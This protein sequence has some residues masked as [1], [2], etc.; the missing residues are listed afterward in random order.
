M[1]NRR[2]CSFTLCKNFIKETFNKYDNIKNINF[3]IIEVLDNCIKTSISI[4]DKTRV[5]DILLDKKKKEVKL[6]SKNNLKNQESY[7]KTSNCLETFNKEN[8]RNAV[9]LIEETQKKDDIIVF[10]NL[11]DFNSK[12]ENVNN[13][14][15]DPEDTYEK[16]STLKEN[17]K[18]DELFIENKKIDENISLNNINDNQSDI[19]SENSEYDDEEPENEYDHND[20]YYKKYPEVF[21]CYDCYET[22]VDKDELFDVAQEYIDKYNLINNENKILKNENENLKNELVDKDKKINIYIKEYNNLLRINNELKELMENE[23]IDIDFMTELNDKFME[24]FLINKKSFDYIADIILTI[25]KT[26]PKKVAEIINKNINKYRNDI[27]DI[28]NEAD[29]IRKRF[30]KLNNDKFGDKIKINK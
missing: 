28:A 8:K 24:L 23:K 19:N 10:N 2:D 3:K 26:N 5:F 20:P 7:D 18:C 4:N 12:T 11:D 14:K 15:M 30:L 29:D 1:K 21:K 25:E 13:K 22:N 6:K 16:K 27:Q 17:N 9:I